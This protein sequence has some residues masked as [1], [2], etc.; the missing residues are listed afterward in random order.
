MNLR[1]RSA[2]GE[3]LVENVDGETT[4]A[5]L[6]SLYAQALSRRDPA[7]AAVP[8]D[9]IRIIYRGRVLPDA[10]TLSSA[11]ITNDS[12][13]HVAIRPA[14]DGG[15][16]EAAGAGAPPPS[17]VPR[18]TT[19]T[20]IYTT[21]FGGAEGANPGDPAPGI[22]DVFRMIQNLQQQAAAGNQPPSA[23]D[24]AGAPSLG[25]APGGA[26]FSRIFG[27]VGNLFNQSAPAAASA[28]P[29]ATPPPPSQAAN[30]ATPSQAAGRPTPT[31]A[32]TTPAP[33]GSPATP[34]A[35]SRP[36]A[37]PAPSARTSEPVNATRAQPA[38]AAATTTAPVMNVHVH[39][40]MAE[41]EQLPARLE[42]FYQETNSRLP[43][44]PQVHI[45]APAGAAATV[46]SIPAAIMTA[47]QQRMSH[48][49]PAAAT[50]AAGGAE[51]GATTAPPVAPGP[52]MSSSVAGAAAG[53][54]GLFSRIM[55]DVS[56]AT[57]ASGSP[58][59]TASART[60][61]TGG[62]GSARPARGDDE[63]DPVSAPLY[64]ELQS[65]L[66]ST[67]QMADGMRMIQGD[68]T[69]AERVREPLLKFIVASRRG[70]PDSP[71]ERE[72]LALVAAAKARKHIERNDD[73]RREVT[74]R[75]KG[76]P[77]DV[78]A[79]LEA[80]VANGN[81]QV[82]DLVV[83]GPPAGVT[84]S[85]AL[86]TLLVRLVG[87]AI[88]YCKR[89]LFRTDADVDAVVSTLTQKAMRTLAQ[90]RPE[91]AMLTM[92]G[93]IVQG[94]ARNW[95][96]EYLER[97]RRPD[98]DATVLSWK[99]KCIAARPPPSSADVAAAMPASPSTSLDAMLD[100]AL[101]GIAAAPNSSIAATVP[102]SPPEVANLRE[103][104]LAAA[105]PTTSSSAATS[106]PAALRQRIL[107]DAED[108]VRR[109]APVAPSEAYFQV[110][111]R[112]VS[113]V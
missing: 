77:A 108:T 49:A 72:R 22:P 107:G 68:W 59:T 19:T 27:L 47:V 111:P 36:P 102:A 40:T 34:A 58:A 69:P 94:C 70:E 5:G 85:G 96:V 32:P 110:Y 83:D 4:A 24:A 56:A 51:P 12:V 33:T 53:L 100:D 89:E 91:M 99:P 46:A 104:V 16:P 101:G 41:L 74:P 67:F 20:R 84:F 14:G 13:V 63:D 2:N 62:G 18:P 112:S 15:G 65:A 105:L 106:V 48:A 71:Q 1:C 29:A 87:H 26:D 82:I 25:A 92:A 28:P 79:F 52:S 3:V 57:R 75:C 37:T 55:S 50:P 64:A 93:P 44:Q 81:R 78:L 38:V 35:A 103:V 31:P 39:V 66:T 54:G 90:E 6:K 43:V 23:A 98:D 8:E 80:A 7:T 97:H 76:T 88:D 60:A 10:V 30:N 113:V 9:R 11:G 86:R 61:A 95:A 73:F 42:R 109:G 17:Q 21:T 45:A